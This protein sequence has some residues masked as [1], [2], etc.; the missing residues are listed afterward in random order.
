MKSFLLLPYCF[1]IINNNE[2]YF[3][4]FLLFS[5]KEAEVETWQTK[6][7]KLL[8]PTDTIEGKTL[9]YDWHVRTS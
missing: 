9:P 2:N 8:R 4:V 3:W 7:F 5:L 1:I 6:S